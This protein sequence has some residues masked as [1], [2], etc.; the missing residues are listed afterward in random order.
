MIYAIVCIATTLRFSLT[1]DEILT[2]AGDVS[3]TGLYALERLAARRVI[4]QA[5]NMYLARH[6]V[7]AEVIVDSL[8]ASGQLL[9]PYLGLARAIAAR[10][11]ASR[12]KSRE[13]KL[14]AALLSHRRISRT[15]AISDGRTVYSEVESFCSDDYHF[16]LQ[17]GSLEVQDGLLEYARPY[18]LSAKDGDGVKAGGEL[19]P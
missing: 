17:R 16:W 4:S 1:R 7:I 11:D 19:T 3:N 5:T 6:R 12:P 2:A 14:V 18:L 8:R 10:Q 9:Q 13:S 15:F